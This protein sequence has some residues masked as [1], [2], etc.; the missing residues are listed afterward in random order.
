MAL[1][2]VLTDLL[3]FL[4]KEKTMLHSITGIDMSCLCMIVLVFVRLSSISTD[5]ET[6]IIICVRSCSG[7]PLFFS[8]VVI[9]WVQEDETPN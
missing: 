9:C 4:K 7:N 8:S 6:L 3:N 5:E 1:T 2:N